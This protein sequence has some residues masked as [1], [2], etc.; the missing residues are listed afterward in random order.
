MVITKYV[1]R[2]PWLIPGA[3]SDPE[4]G[5]GEG[6]GWAACSSSAAWARRIR[7]TSN[8][9]SSSV[10]S[11]STYSVAQRLQRCKQPLPGLSGLQDGRQLQ[12]CNWQPTHNS[13]QPCRPGMV[14]LPAAFPFTTEYRTL[15]GS[16]ATCLEPRW[17]RFERIH[18]M[19]MEPYDDDVFFDSPRLVH[20]L[21]SQAARG[22]SMPFP[23][24]NVL[25]F[26]HVQ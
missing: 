8:R 12:R 25:S 19:R 18:T 24:H 13:L 1:W 22:H 16:R 9:T 20:A 11:Q 4:R 15:P 14:D 23:W 6:H 26:R 7:T 2:C 21:I 17:L 5:H 10:I 3:S